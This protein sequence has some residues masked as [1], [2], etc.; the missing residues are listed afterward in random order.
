V[1]FPVKAVVAALANAV[2][3]GTAAVL[4]QRSTKQVS[5]QKNPL[6][7]RLIIDL[8][9]RPLWLIAIVLNITGVVLQIIALHYGALALVQPIL[10]CD[11][12]FATLI[13][14]AFRHQW[15]DWEILLGVL[16][17]AGGLA[18]FLAV[19]RPHGG[20]AT[21][22]PVDAIPLAI[23][24]GAALA[25][26]LLVAATGPRMLR[27]IMLALACGISYGVTAFVFKLLS[28]GWAGGLSQLPYQWPL[29]A[30]VVVGPLGFLLNQSAYQAGILVSPVLAVI[31][32]VDPLVSI[33]LAVGLLNET[34]SGGALNITME[35]VAL[36]VMIAGI[37]ILSH[38][39]PHV[40]DQAKAAA[41]AREQ[42]VSAE[43]TL[44]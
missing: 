28:G 10:V 32:A 42:P 30:A 37:V 16:C 1:G 29:Y 40:A 2:N 23:A 39:A 11:L 19:A 35:A 8:L 4:E 25:G 15:P 38:R 17:C 33:A 5:T 6:S 7:V 26:C 34:I 22:S 44:S 9:R 27:P 41:A 24:Y 36:L 14:S 20:V 12:I 13:A 18:L 43:E 21:V 3:D 31:T